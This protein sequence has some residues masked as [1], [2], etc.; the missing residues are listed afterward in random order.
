MSPSGSPA[1]CSTW[2]ACA[3]PSSSSRS[4]AT[5]TPRSSPSRDYGVVGDLYQLVPAITEALYVTDD[6]PARSTSTSSSSARASRA[7]SRPTSSPEQ[8]HS[9]VLIE[10]G[11]TPG[12]KNLSGGVLYCRGMQQVFPD[13]LDRG[14][15][16][17]ADH[18]QLHQ[19]P[20]CRLAR[21]ASTTGTRGWPTRSTPSRCCVPSSTRGWP[22]SAKRP[23]SSSCPACGWTGC[24][25]R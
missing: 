9:V 3:A 11:E 25:P 16:R 5:R 14:P 24:S 8:G 20:Q 10:R 6:E 21:S 4:T 1:S 23:A 15:G 7:A 19:L 22:R 12:A 17:A 13:F 18:P 2:S